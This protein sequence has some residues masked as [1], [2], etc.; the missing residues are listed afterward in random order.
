[1][2]C[3]L[4]FEATEDVDHIQLKRKNATLGVDYVSGVNA[5]YSGIYQWTV[6][7]D[8]PEASADHGEAGLQLKFGP[9]AWFAYEADPRWAGPQDRAIADYSHLFITRAKTR[10]VQQSAVTL[11][12]SLD[13]LARDDHRLHDEIVALMTS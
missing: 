2:F 1:M 13:G 12:E 9:S 5:T 7:F 4:T 3:T 8:T 11:A 6:N 10:Q